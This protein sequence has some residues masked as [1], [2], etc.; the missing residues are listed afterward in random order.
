MCVCVSSSRSV[1]TAVA[2]LAVAAAWPLEMLMKVKRAA[3]EIV[4]QHVRP[5]VCPSAIFLS[6]W[7]LLLLQLLL[8][9]SVRCIESCRPATVWQLPCGSQC[10]NERLRLLLLLRHMRRVVIETFSVCCCCCCWVSFLRGNFQHTRGR[11]KFFFYDWRR[12]LLEVAAVA[13]CGMLAR[14]FGFCL[15]C[16]PL[17]TSLTTLSHCPSVV[18]HMRRMRLLFQRR[19]HTSCHTCHTAGA[20]VAEVARGDQQQS[21]DWESESENDNSTAGNQFALPAIAA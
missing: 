2:A 16:L 3:S 18:A 8:M 11:F 21:R 9:L 7:Q 1:A 10:C 19:T 20:E 14:T 12:F 4:Q 17:P 6:H 15:P 13:A 5:S